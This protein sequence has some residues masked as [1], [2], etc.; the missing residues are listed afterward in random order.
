M[1]LPSS[2]PELGAHHPGIDA[3]A[4]QTLPALVTTVPDPKTFC[5]DEECC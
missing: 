4:A 3:A 2:W 5:D 1:G